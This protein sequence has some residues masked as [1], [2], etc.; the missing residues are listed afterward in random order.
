MTL[1]KVAPYDVAGFR[2]NVVRS[3]SRMLAATLRRFV[4]DVFLWVTP[5]PPSVKQ[6]SRLQRTETM[7]CACFSK[8]CNKM[9]LDEA[10]NSDAHN[11][12]LRIRSGAWQ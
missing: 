3:P 2:N 1:K 11:A 9:S 7:Y 5:K 8:L 6:L 12:L 4:D 10:K